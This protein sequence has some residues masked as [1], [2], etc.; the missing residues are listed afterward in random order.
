[1]EKCVEPIYHRFGDEK[2]VV[3]IKNEDLT[4]KYIS[5]GFIIV[6]IILASFT[7]VSFFAFLYNI[8]PKITLI[9]GIFGI[10]CFIV[11]WFIAHKKIYFEDDK[12]ILVNK[13]KKITTID[14]KKYPRIY[15]KH[16]VS[17]YYD[18]NYGMRTVSKYVFYIEQNDKNI[19]LDIDEIGLK[20]I[21]IFLDNLIMKE[22][23]DITQEQWEASNTQ[24]EKNM[25]FYMEF[26]DKQKKII[27]VKNISNNIVVVNGIDS[28]SSFIICTLIMVVCGLLT[29]IM[30]ETVTKIILPILCVLFMYDVFFFIN[31]LERWKNY[32]FKVSYPSKG[33]IKINNYILD[34]ETTDISLKII[35]ENSTTA[36]SKYKYRLLIVSNYY[37][38]YINLNMKQEDIIYELIDNLIFEA[39][40]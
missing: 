28:K 27:G 3:G 20:E 15:L 11:T 7:V 19:I 18:E 1:M 31:I 5:I 26:L 24:K 22:K 10:I 38:Y 14:V 21:N 39:K 25:A 37:N 4:I 13:F 35:R 30:S 29:V 34:Y 2:V 23:N 9:S 8:M 6:L 32:Y 36:S 40:E 33:M 17:N 12:I 16:I